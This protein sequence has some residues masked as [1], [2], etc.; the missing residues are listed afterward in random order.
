M[1]ELTWQKSS[2][3]GELSA[4]VNVA[5]TPDGAVAIRESDDPDVI[6]TVSPGALRGLIRAIK[7]G[8]D[9]L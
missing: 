1:S 9:P 4:C 3:S 8:H 6:V 7:G 5:T 2:F